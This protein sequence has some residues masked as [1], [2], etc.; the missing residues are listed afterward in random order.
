[1]E[2]LI[3]FLINLVSGI[4][5]GN[6]VAA[7]LKKISLGVMG[8]TLAGLVGG[9]VAGQ[10]LESAGGG[11]AVAESIA[12]V[13]GGAVFTAIVGVIRKYVG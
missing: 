8:N 7:F 5:G 4:A 12:G 6:L 3:P 2:L 11:G 13:I 10:L 1:M 9:G